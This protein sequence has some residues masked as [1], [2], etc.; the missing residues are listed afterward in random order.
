MRWHSDRVLT[1]PPRFAEE[2]VRTIKTSSACDVVL[3]YLGN[4]YT[5][6]VVS[7]SRRVAVLFQRNGKTLC[8]LRFI[9]GHS[10]AGRVDVKG[11]KV[12]DR[13][14]SVIN[15]VSAFLEELYK[16][17]MSNIPLHEGDLKYIFN[18]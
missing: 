13:E 5:L 15:L 9:R 4:H 8:E 2:A 7:K 12:T 14:S 3:E 6:H 1:D 18:S 10:L 16:G 17:D 11:L